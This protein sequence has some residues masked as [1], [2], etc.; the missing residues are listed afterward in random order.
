MLERIIHFLN[1]LSVFF[2]FAILFRFAFAGFTI[3]CFYLV[4]AVEGPLLLIHCFR[5]ESPIPPKEAKIFF[6]LLVFASLS[7]ST[8]FSKPYIGDYSDT[9][10]IKGLV[11]VVFFLVTCVIFMLY[12]SAFSDGATRFYSSLKV[13]LRI[14]I[15]YSL[16]QGFLGVLGIWSNEILVRFMGLNPPEAS[17]RLG[18]F[19]RLNGLTWDSNFLAFQALIYLFTEFLEYQAQQIK[20]LSFFAFAAIL[21]ILFSFSRSG[22]LGLSFFL[23]VSS[24]FSANWFKKL[25]GRLL[26]TLLISLIIFGFL[27]EIVSPI[28]E[29]R[30]GRHPNMFEMLRE[31]VRT[32]YFLLGLQLIISNPLGIGL[33]NSSS[34][35]L[36]EL[37]YTHFKFHNAFLTLAVE[38]GV[39]AMLIYFV[40][41]L[42]LIYYRKTFINEKSII[43]TTMILTN[44]FYDQVLWLFTWAFLVVFINEPFRDTADTSLMRRKTPGK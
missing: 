34:F 17:G 8:F 2:V 4:I 18:D 16:F 1:A 43:L 12:T 33:N 36:Q 29:D 5:T 10:F 23:L 9:Q 30:F 25:A 40:I 32:Q 37:G 41:I 15:L 22:I 19:M 35:A 28:I 20:K 6:L 44:L 39:I 3:Y 24:I 21:V 13:S 26:F 31:D 42:K 11:N 27:S 7:I 38:N 14:I